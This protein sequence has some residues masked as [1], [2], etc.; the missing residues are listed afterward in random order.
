MLCRRGACFSRAIFSYTEL[1][2]VV[3]STLAHVGGFAVGMV[4]L[5]K[6]KMDSRAWVYTFLWYL[7]VQ[8]TAR[9]ITPAAMNVNLSHNIQ[10]GWEQTF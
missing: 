8:L 9:L 1:L 4:A 10:A 5:R 2:G 3:S 6:V 7:I